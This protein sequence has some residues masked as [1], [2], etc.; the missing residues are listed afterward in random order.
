MIT[1]IDDLKWRYAVDKFDPEKE[2]DPNIIDQ[3]CE[4]VRLA[5]SSYGL[6][7]IKLLVITNREL[8]KE[9]VSYSYNQQQVY[10]CSHLFILCT[11]NILNEELIEQ[12][13]ARTAAANQKLP[14]EY[15]KYCEFLKKNI[16]KMTSYEMKQWNDKQA[17]IALGHLLHT[18]AQLRVDST[19]ME[20]FQKD[21]YDEILKLSEQNL[22]SV[23]LCPIGYRSK[24]D[25][26]QFWPKI[27]KTKEEFV[28]FYS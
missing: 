26:Q 27:R 12:H 9:L 6:Q 5:P 7:P 16:L 1:P 22:H 25:E 3:L 15:S 18:C 17:Y 24:T 28:A 13:I 23:V 11:H 2:V 10:D 8:R 20:G 19:P 4:A 21:M 14:Q